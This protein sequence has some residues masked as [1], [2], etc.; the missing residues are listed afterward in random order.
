MDFGN[1]LILVSAGLI[2]LSIFAGTASARVGAPLLLVFLA[3]GM[4]AGE[5]GLGGLEFDDFQTAYIVGATSLAIVLFDGGLRTRVDTLKTAGGPALTLATI[6][7]AVTAGVVGGAAYLLMDLSWIEALLVGS[8][9]A[10][11]DAAAVFFLLNVGDIRLARRV[12]ATLEVESGMNDPMAV[13]LVVTCIALLE[14]GARA[15][16]WSHLG[17]FAVGFVSQ[18]VGGTII[19]LACGYA[20]VG[21]INRMK[22]DDGL[23]PIL[24]LAGALLI[25]SAS[26][27]AH[28]SGF[29]AVYLAGVV[30]G[31]RRHRA[32][33]VI[34]R[35]QDGIAWLSQIVMFVMLGLL[36]TPRDLVD[37]L[38]PA[39]VISGVLIF[40]ARPIATVLSLLP[41]RFGRREHIFISWVGLRGA[42]PIFLGAM[43]VM[44]GV[45]GARTY[46]DIA[47]VVVLTSLL[48]QGWTIVPAAHFLKL[49][50]PARAGAPVRR[51]IDLPMDVGR[52]MAAYAVQ[53]GSMSTKLRAAD[54]RERAGVEFVAIMREGQILQ[55]DSVWRFLP[56]DQVLVLGGEDSAA[57]LETIFGTAPESELSEVEEAVLGEFSFDPQIRMGDLA[58]AYEFPIPTSARELTAD[59]FLRRHRRRK[60]EAGDRFRV[61]PV[62]LVVQAVEDGRI[63]RVGIELDP[64]GASPLSRDNLRLWMRHLVDRWRPTLKRAKTD[65]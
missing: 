11:T 36:V 34:D 43:P 53:D 39:L 37:S 13:F 14:S 41:F 45:E 64:E 28:A 10:S 55:P 42:V 29:L 44:L 40:L 51:D 24:A 19:G 61:G 27:F 30:V 6:G 32:R 31:H 16:E 33:Q 21:L 7:V 3:L 59:E 15:F 22:L 56:G 50:L 57:K 49:A 25:Y 20:L 46:F 2:L 18:M 63:T 54:I 62:E 1:A 5:D 38:V 23:Y 48:I 12:R 58:A 17:S 4:L 26:H 35:F 8:I 9:V 65:G 47:F 60:P 52:D